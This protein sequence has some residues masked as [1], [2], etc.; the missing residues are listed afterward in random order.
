V[1]PVTM[2]DVVLAG[3]PLDGQVVRLP[4]FVA[5]Y[6][7]ARPPG[8]HVYEGGPATGEARRTFRY[9]GVRGRG[10]GA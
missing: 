10:E 9:A 5:V 4:D 2:T 1:V 6:E 3:G 8:W 7:K